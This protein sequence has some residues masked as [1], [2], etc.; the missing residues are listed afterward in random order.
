ML[1]QKLVTVFQLASVISPTYK[2]CPEKDVTTST[3]EVIQ[4]ST[5]TSS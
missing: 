3:T 4:N 5:V 1:K 2:K